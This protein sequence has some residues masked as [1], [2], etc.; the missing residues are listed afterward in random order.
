MLERFSPRFTSR[1]R[2][3]WFSS[4]TFFVAVESETRSV[5]NGVVEKDTERIKIKQSGRYRSSP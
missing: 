1:T 4:R 5:R 2:L 3:G